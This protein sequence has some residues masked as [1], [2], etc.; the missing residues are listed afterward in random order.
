MLRRRGQAGAHVVAQRLGAVGGREEHVDLG[1]AVRPAAAVTRPAR[2]GSRRRSGAGSGK[3]QLRKVVRGDGRV[4]R[5]RAAAQ[6]LVLGAEEHLG[7]L[8][9]RERLEA[10]DSRV[11]SD[12][13]H[14][15]TWTADRRSS[16]RRGATPAR[17]HSASVGRRLPAQ[18]AYASAS[19]QETCCTGSSGVQRLPVAEARDQP[20]RASVGSSRS[21]AQPAAQSVAARGQELGELVRSSRARESIRNGVQLDLVRRPLVVVGPRL[22]VRAHHERARR[23]RAPPR[24][25][26]TGA[27]TA[28]LV[29]EGRASWSVCSIVSTCCCSCWTTIPKTK[30]SRSS[31]SA[32]SSS[33][34]V[35][36]VE[37]AARVP[38]PT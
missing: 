24:R 4:R 33:D 8:G 17:S 9:V 12:A 15:Q 19:Y 26:A 27:R 38:R 34:L 22:V 20:R 37:R 2:T 10:R 30:P 32:G 35:E 28:A 16:S 11:K 13:V 21:H 6:H 14:S 1:A 5:P 3:S 25:A 36:H 18:R 7:V 31:R 23:R 29:R